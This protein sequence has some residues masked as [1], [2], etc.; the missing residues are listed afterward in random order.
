MDEG[1]EVT[2]P[3]RGWAFQL[4]PARPRTVLRVKSWT[5]SSN[6]TRV[7]LAG[8]DLP[9]QVGGVTKGTLRALC[10]GPGDWLLVHTH[11][12]VASLHGAWGGELFAQS[13]AL[14]DLTAGLTSLE[15]SGSSVRAIL[16]MSC[17]LDFDPRKFTG[18]RCA[19]ARFAQIPV[20][21]DCIQAEELFELYVPRSYGPYL[22]NWLE[23][24]ACG[25][26]PMSHS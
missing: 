6:D 2:A 1:L 4:R 13:L 11:P 9:E 20:V 25:L 23:D 8:C 24:A 16:E 3:V 15:V 26:A 21:I 14:V 10:L 12:Q 19:R 5:S 17:G 7:R 22:Q 18:G